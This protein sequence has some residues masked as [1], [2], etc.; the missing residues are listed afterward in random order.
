[1]SN[2][3]QSLINE[4]ITAKEGLI[5]ERNHLKEVLAT[6]DLEVA[7]IYK[8]NELIETITTLPSFRP[9]VYG[10][11]IDETQQDPETA[12][13]YIE[14]SVGIEKAVGSDL[15]GW[16]NI[17]PFNKI[18]PVGFKNGTVYKEIKKENFKKY[19]DETDVD[20]TVDVM[21]EIPRVYWKFTKI[22]NGYEIRISAKKIDKDYKCLA[23]TVGET[24]KSNI[25]IG[26][27]VGYRYYTLRSVTGKYS[28][29]KAHTST[30]R[31]SAQS[32]GAGYQMYNYYSHLL[33][34]ILYL[35]AYKN[36]DSSIALGQGLW[37]SQTPGG[38]DEKG[39]NY[40]SQDN[41]EPVKFLGVEDFWGNCS[42][43]VDGICTNS[44]KDILISN[45]ADFNNEGTNY[46]IISQN[47]TGL[48][49][50]VGGYPSKVVGGTETGFIIKEGVSSS[51]DKPNY[52]DWANI[53][54][55]NGY[56]LAMS[57][58]KMSEGSY[59]AFNFLI[60]LLSTT[61]YNNVASRLVF[62]GTDNGQLEG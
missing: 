57:N 20:E 33:L 14:D 37:Y 19:I 26:A 11:R 62:L 3:M 58:L 43:L 47:E 59:G 27:Y 48:T 25:Y 46:K 4:L 35:V 34:Q 17:Y 40:G 38:A 2:T 5:N 50:N 54:F 29:E 60:N 16:L 49:K 1:M 22:E 51:N 56:S 8:L 52:G 21:I 53:S 61:T 42:I 36:L 13:T 32:A 55:M 39:L 6:K 12:V 44:N 7:N 30:F 45:N 31:Q 9:P 24:E 18:R 41:T 28:V 15:K 10:I 23:H